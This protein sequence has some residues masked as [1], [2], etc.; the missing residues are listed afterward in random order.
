MTEIETAAGGVVI[1]YLQ[2][3]NYLLRVLFPDPS[4]ADRH[5]NLLL[6]RGLDR[7]GLSLSLA[8]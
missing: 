8:K 4:M 1:P 3:R 5:N 6:A 7:S 2:Y